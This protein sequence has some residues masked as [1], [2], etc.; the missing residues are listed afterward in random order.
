[1]N[2]KLPFSLLGEL[3]YKGNI[4]IMEVAKFYQTAS[5]ADKKK[6]KGLLEAGKQEAAWAL[7]QSVTG[8]QLEK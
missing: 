5:E 4:G 6:L 8:V 1:M 3:A 2:E 7:I